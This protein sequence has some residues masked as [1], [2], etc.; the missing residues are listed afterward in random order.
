M[1]KNVPNDILTPKMNKSRSEWVHVLILHGPCPFRIM[2]VLVYK[3]TSLTS[4]H[5]A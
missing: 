3:D 2:Y 1:V 5:N 4:C